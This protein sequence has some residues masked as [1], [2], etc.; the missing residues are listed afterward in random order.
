SHASTSLSYAYGLAVA[1]DAAAS[2]APDGTGPAHVVAVIGD[3]ALTGGLAYEALNNIGYT[4]RRVVI[5]LNDNGR[6]YA[7]TVSRLTASTD[8]PG[9][10]EAFVRALGVDYAGPF[11]GH[12]VAALE[13]ALGAAAESDGPVVVHVVTHKG[14]GYAPAEDD[15]EKR[16]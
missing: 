13:H 9:A 4:R 11:D 16:L 15:D 1:R 10:T 14:Q 2:S 12:D 3:G 5:V 7:P 6:C 8:G